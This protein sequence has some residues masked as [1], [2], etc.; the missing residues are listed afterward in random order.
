MEKKLNDLLA[1]KLAIIVM[2]K[3]VLD[4]MK[5]A[6]K[7]G[8]PVK[9]WFATRSAEAWMEVRKE[10]MRDLEA[11]VAELKLDIIT[12]CQKKGLD[13]NDFGLFDEVKIDLKEKEGK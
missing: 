2:D 6:E 7:E 4:A 9:I 1:E 13:P 11:R 8:N 3:S 12:E 5:A 10:K